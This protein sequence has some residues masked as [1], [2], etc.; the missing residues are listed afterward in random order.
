MRRVQSNRGYRY[1]KEEHGITVR[2]AILDPPILH[3][4]KYDWLEVTVSLPPRSMRSHSTK[5]LYSKA[6]MQY[7][8]VRHSNFHTPQVSFLQL[9]PPQKLR[10]DHPHTRRYQNADAASVRAFRIGPLFFQTHAA[11]DRKPASTS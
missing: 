7:E 6:H 5:V 3:A 2:A 11:P 1:R 9:F 8:Q 10:V 4:T